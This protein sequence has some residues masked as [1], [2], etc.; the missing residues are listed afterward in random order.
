MV[1]KDGEKVAEFTGA[2]DGDTL[3]AAIE[4]QL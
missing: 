1:F 3:R 2:Q 4:S